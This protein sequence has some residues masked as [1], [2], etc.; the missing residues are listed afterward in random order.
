M[1]PNRQPARALHLAG[2]IIIFATVAIIERI[3]HWLA[4]LARRMETAFFEKEQS[5]DQHD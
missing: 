5:N 1:I 2:I 3:P 4:K